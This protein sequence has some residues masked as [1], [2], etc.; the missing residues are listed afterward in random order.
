MRISGGKIVT[1][2][3]LGESLAA[4]HADIAR[5]MEIDGAAP[6]YHVALGLIDERGGDRPGAVHEYGAALSFAPEN[7]DSQFATD[8]KARDPAMWRMCLAAAVSRLRARNPDGQDVAIQA[9]VARLR[10]EEGEHETARRMLE[11]VTAAMPQFSRAWANLGYLEFAGGDPQGG[12][13]SLRKAV[14][15]DG[16]FC[17]A[18]LLLA[19]IERE[20]GD[21]GSAASLEATCADTGRTSPSQHARRLHLTYK[22]TG[23]FAGDDVLPPGLL[24]YCTPRQYA[25]T[26]VAATPAF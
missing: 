12:E 6:Q 21:E 24:A 4:V 23:G 13:L 7:A 5:S 25:E 2:Y 20:A 22:V 26:A 14:F 3:T 18:R 1:R 10:M 15:L 16:G 17:P 11:R 8:L 9:A 19:R